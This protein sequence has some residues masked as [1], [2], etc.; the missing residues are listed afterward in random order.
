MSLDDKKIL[1]KE[2]KIKFTKDTTEEELDILIEKNKEEAEKKALELAEKKAA[3]EARELAEKNKS[4]I[5]LKDTL[6]KD[7]DQKDYFFPRLV[8][9]KTLDGTILPVTDQ[10][11][12]VYFNKMCGVPVERE[13]LIEVFHNAFGKDKGFLFYKSISQELYLIIVPLKYATTVSRSN[14]SQAGHFQRHA[15][16]FINE[17]SVNA[18][19]LKLKL[20]KVAKHPSISKE[21]LA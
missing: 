1:A 14:D 11:A 7:V 8:E 4:K 18:D 21:P 16:S 19:S 3:E 12:P 17:G 9:E 5:I 6:G 10:T 15:L 2:L 13:E 20:A